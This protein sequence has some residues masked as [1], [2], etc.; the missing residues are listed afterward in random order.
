L[1]PLSWLVV[2]VPW[3]WVQ[4]FLLAGLALGVVLES[5]RLSGRAD[6]RIFRAL[7]REY[8][9]E[10]PAGY[11]LYAVGMTVTGL[12]FPPLVAAPAMLMLT[13]ADPFSGLLY[14]GGLGRKPA[15]V[16][17]LTFL[18]CLS[19]AVLADVPLVPAA[20]GALAAALADG[21]TP[22]I[23]GYVIDD[24][25]TIPIVAAAAM[26]IGVALVP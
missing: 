25:A 23:R 18:A 15:P 26:W 4:Y 9:R 10:N 12:V 3:R 2:G 5:L 8:E 6:W 21:A 11:F 24:N 1:I 13:L 14:A 7:I 17:A 20:L 19:I 16:I 22:V